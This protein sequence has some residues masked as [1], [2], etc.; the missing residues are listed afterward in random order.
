MRPSIMQPPHYQLL[1]WP[2]SRSKEVP[3]LAGKSAM[4][5]LKVSQELLAVLLEAHQQ[6]HTTPVPTIALQVHTTRALRTRLIPAWILI[7][8][9]PETWVLLALR[10][11]M[12]VGLP[13]L[14]MIPLL[15]RNLD[16]WTS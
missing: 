13:A 5:A 6:I 9:A 14:D 12:A 15:T 3:Y 10:V 7:W 4:T 8:M 2:T 1:V 11:A 16:S